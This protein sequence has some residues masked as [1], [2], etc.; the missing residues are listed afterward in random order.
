MARARKAGGAVAEV[1]ARM[2]L[3]HGDAKDLLPTLQP[4]VVTV[5]TMYPARRKS[6]LPK[7]EMRL[8]RDIVGLD[9]DAGELMK[10]ALATA[11]KRVVLKRP[12]LAAPLP[13]IPAPSHQIIGKSTR[14][15]VFMV[16]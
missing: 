11:D 14:Y 5:D 16:G 13:G 9:E 3:M 7:S 6:A 10:V 1:M 12:R 2:T 4:E 8:V 15:D